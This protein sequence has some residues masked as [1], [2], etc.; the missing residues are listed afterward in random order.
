MHSV[1]ESYRS[2]EWESMLAPF[3]GFNQRLAHHCRSPGL[4]RVSTTSSNEPHV[5]NSSWTVTRPVHFLNSGTCFYANRTNGSLCEVSLEKDF[6]IGPVQQVG[7][8]PEVIRDIAQLDREQLIIAVENTVYL[9]GRGE[10]T[11]RGGVSCILEQEGTINMFEPNDPRC[12]GRDLLVAVGRE[13][14]CNDL[15]RMKSHFKLEFRPSC[16]LISSVKW[17]SFGDPDIVS[18]TTTLGKLSFFDKRTGG[19][20][21]QN[22]FV[23][24]GLYAHT[25][26]GPYSVGSAGLGGIIRTFDTRR[27]EK[28]VAEFV[29]PDLYDIGELVVQERRLFAF[30]SPG[31]TQWEIQDNCSSLQ[32][33]SFC[34]NNQQNGGS[35]QEGQ[36]KYFMRG[37]IGE[38]GI[39]FTTDSNGDLSLWSAT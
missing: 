5:P 23:Q 36:T 22:E 24:E 4:R 2:F 13:L 21:I 38:F 1:T 37:T 18:A 26:L 34:S 10:S 31:F 30:G 8:F 33:R 3:E 32:F 20:T 17:S 19:L 9:W 28:H 27:I 12:S 25:T 7:A 35:G 15:E 14:W 11:G 6:T 16:G 39:L 29:D